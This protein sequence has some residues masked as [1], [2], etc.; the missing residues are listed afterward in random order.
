LPEGHEEGLGDQVVGHLAAE[1]AGEVTLD[2][3][4]VPVEDHGEPLRSAR[5]ALDDRRVVLV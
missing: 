4:R 5:R 2:V 1:P 3:G